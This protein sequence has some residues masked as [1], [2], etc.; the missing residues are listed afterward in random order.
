MTNKPLVVTAT[1][2][3]KIYAAQN[4]VG[5]T[6]W[7][8]G[9]HRVYWNMAKDGMTAT[10]TNSTVTVGCPLDY[11]V[12]DL[13]AG[14]DAAAYPIS[15]LDAAPAGGWTDEHKTTKLVLRRV[16]AGS[17]IMGDN[18][19]NESHRVTVKGAPRGFYS[20]RVDK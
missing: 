15:F 11:L 10:V 2:G 6:N 19:S 16:E 17:F 8:N 4:L 20:I 1:D 12:V 9:A 18:S 3:N 14:T 5:A 7:A 13:S